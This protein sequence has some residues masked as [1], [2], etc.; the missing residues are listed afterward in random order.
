MVPLRLRRPSRQRTRSTRRTSEDFS[1]ARRS[2]ARLAAA[3]G[4]PRLAVIDQEL[5]TTPGGPATQTADGTGKV[6][7]EQRFSPS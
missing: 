3:V 5:T 6:L 4:R 1:A 2:S 7:H